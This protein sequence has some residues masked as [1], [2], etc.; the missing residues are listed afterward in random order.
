[1]QAGALN[2]PPLWDRMDAAPEIQGK[3]YVKVY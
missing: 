1:M 3:C 2:A